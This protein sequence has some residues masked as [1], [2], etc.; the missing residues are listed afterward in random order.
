MQLGFVS[1]LLGDLDL[2]QVLAF[3]AEERFDCVEVMC[4]PRDGRFTGVSHLDVSD[5]SQGRADDTRGLCEK[6]GIPFS[7]LGYY[8]NPL[9]ADEDEAQFARQHLRRVIDAAA[10]LGLATVNT[11][12]GAHP[13][14]SLD[15]NL[16]DFARVWPELVRYAEERNVRLGIENCPMLIRETWP[17]G[18]NLARSPGIWRQMFETIPSPNFGL[19]IDPSHLV[20]QLMD[21]LA[22]IA[23]FRDKL[24]HAH[25]KDMKIE[26]AR[27]NEIGVYVPAQIAGWGTPKIPGLGEV[28]WGL[29]ISALTDAHYDGPVCIE[30][31]DEAFAGDLEKRKRSLRISRDV[32]RPLIG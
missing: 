32:L 27:L 23:E 4:W 30:V 13:R 8:P 19:N 7:A 24:F 18:I 15:E 12:I 25:A 31:E 10:L 1:A 3:A 6:Y 21:Y 17:F 20:M 9:A 14:K 28:N 16:A 22:P 26:R 29:W 11:F 5:F 2:E